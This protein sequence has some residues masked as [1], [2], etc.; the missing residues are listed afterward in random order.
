[1]IPAVVMAPIGA[2]VGAHTPDFIL[3]VIFTLFLS[4]TLYNLIT[5]QKRQKRSKEMTSINAI[6]VGIGIGGIAGFLG[7]LLG[8]GG[9]LIILPV[10]TFMEG[11]FKKIAGTTAYIALF[12]SMSGFISYL[13]ILHGINYILWIAVLLGGAIGGI[14][15]S[16]LMHRFNS[17]NVRILIIIIV[18]FILAKT[19]YSLIA[20]YT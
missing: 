14:T 10:L 16:A 6:L 4:Y 8:V 15:G 2:I 20:I 3:L 13:L 9:G 7:G 19:A 5:S 11:D 18:V 1:M 17:K 12:S